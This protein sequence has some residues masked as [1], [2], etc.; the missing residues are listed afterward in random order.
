MGW[1]QELRRYLWYS[2]LTYPIFSL[3]YVPF[4]L[5][6]VGLNPQQFLTNFVDG[7]FYAMIANFILSAWVLEV[8]EFI[9][10]RERRR[11]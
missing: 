9:Q 11:P 2:A 5:W 7:L 6:V 3:V 8:S 4:D 10:R 1:K